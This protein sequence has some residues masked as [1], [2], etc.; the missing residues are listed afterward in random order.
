MK[1]LIRYFFLPLLALNFTYSQTASD[2]FPANTG[3]VWYSLGTPLDSLNNPIDSLKFFRADSFAVQTIYQGENS[4]LILSSYSGV[5]YIYFS[6]Y[7]DS[8]FIKLDGSKA[9]EYLAF[10]EMID[11]VI[12]FIFDSS[13]ISQ[14]TTLDGWYPF[15]DFAAT[16][17][18]QVELF[19]QDFSVNLDTLNINLRV[20]GLTERLPDESIE[21]PAGVFNTKKFN[22]KI[23]FFFLLQ[24]LPPPLPPQEFPF[25]TMERT[26]WIA[27]NNWIVKEFYPATAYDFSQIGGQVINTPG[28]M[29]ERTDNPL[30]VGVDDNSIA[31]SEFSLQQ[32]YPNPFN[33]STIINFE[34]PKS[35]F[36]KL[37]VYNSLGQLVTTL[38]N[39]TKAKGKYSVEFNGANLPSGVYIYRIETDNFSASRKM[40]LMK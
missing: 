8:T 30:Q 6:P 40:I 25:F 33:P 34:I 29:F 15:I 20:K 11:S 12:A 5:D 36:V 31:L 35:S 4:N 19:S 18:Q 16:T 7:F 22:N 32:N 38:V 28:F 14:L 9:Y 3:T 10:N 24:I 2:F 23:S 17:N 1:N 39:E 26:I 21:V 37:R 13:F 27:E